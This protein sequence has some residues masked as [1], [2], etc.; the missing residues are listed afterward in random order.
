VLATAF[1]AC[2]W[3]VAVASRMPVF[4]TAYALW[5]VIFVCSRWFEMYFVNFY[6]LARLKIDEEQTGSGF[7]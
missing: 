3:P 5:D 7:P 6:V 4:S 1:Y 2:I